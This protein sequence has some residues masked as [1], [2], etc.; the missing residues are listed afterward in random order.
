MARKTTNSNGATR[1]FKHEL[2]AAA[3]VLRGHMDASEY[4][5]VVLGLISLKYISDPFQDQCEAIQNV[6]HAGP[7]APD[8][9]LAE[10][11]FWFP[12]DARWAA[13][14][15]APLSELASSGIRIKD[16]DKLV[17]AAT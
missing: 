10:N 11:V 16:A 7:E 1:G 3:D 2:W 13:G 15:D 4:K 5:H 17:G 9:H 14:R 8:E 6:G 12:A